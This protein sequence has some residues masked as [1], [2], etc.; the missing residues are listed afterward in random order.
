MKII[1]A[2]PCTGKTFLRETSQAVLDF[3]TDFKPLVAE[4]LGLPFSKRTSTALNE[5]RKTT[6]LEQEY[7]AVMRI[8]WPIAKQHALEQQKTLLVSDVMFLRENV[9][10][11]NIVITISKEIFFKRAAF[12]GDEIS[13]L[14]SWKD[15]IDS[16]LQNVPKEKIITT[17]KYMSDII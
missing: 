12:R 1:W 3:D 14:E 11:F 4:K 13:Q 7:K 6:G 10:D 2:H 8:V 16:A 9:A 17:D 15:S 5:W